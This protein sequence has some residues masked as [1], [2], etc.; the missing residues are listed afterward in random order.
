[1]CIRDSSISAFVKRVNEGNLHFQ[2]VRLLLLNTLLST[3]SDGRCL[4][5]DT[6][7]SPVLFKAVEFL[8]MS[9][10]SNLFSM[11]E[12][13]RAG[14]N[15]LGISIYEVLVNMI[16]NI[17]S[18]I[19][20]KKLQGQK[21][22]ELETQKNKLERKVNKWALLLEDSQLESERSSYRFLWAKFC[23]LQ[24]STDILDQRLL[25]SIQ[26][27]ER[28]IEQKVPDINVPVSYTHLDVYK[29]QL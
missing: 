8:I 25:T 10:E 21:V 7:W 3:D 28:A 22:N 24:Y 19:S 23:F 11:I 12:A 1:M 18:N 20:S 17:Y 13:D 29:R 4:I 16:G 27:I 9:V 26:E 14:L 6:F 15:F 5:I 2:E